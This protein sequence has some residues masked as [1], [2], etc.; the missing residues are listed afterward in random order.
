[1]E[2]DIRICTWCCVDSLVFISHCIALTSVRA[3]RCPVFIVVVVVVNDFTFI[4]MSVC[5]TDVHDMVAVHIDLLLPF[6]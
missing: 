1:M 2:I 5:F 4:Q 6:I 3:P